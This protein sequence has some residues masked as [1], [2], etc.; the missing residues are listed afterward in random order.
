M[1]TTV[2]GVPLVICGYLKIAYDVALLYSF[3]DIKPPEER[4]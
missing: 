1:S 2:T 3:R 4:N